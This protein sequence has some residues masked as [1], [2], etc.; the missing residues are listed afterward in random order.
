LARFKPLFTTLATSTL[1]GPEAYRY[2]HPRPK[3]TVTQH[4]HLQALIRIYMF[5]LQNQ[6]G[7]F[8]AKSG[9]WSDGR[10]PNTLFRTLH[11][12]EAANQ[13]FEANSKDYSLRITVI[14]CEM[15]LKKVP[16][17]ASELLPPAIIIEETGEQASLLAAHSNS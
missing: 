13:L 11:R 2:L 12:D 3:K 14:H 16:I 1:K 15:N 8:L 10:E 5:I 4:L 7:Y 6:D 17:I 9:A